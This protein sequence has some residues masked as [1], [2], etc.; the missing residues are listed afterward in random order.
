MRL[1]RAEIKTIATAAAGWGR[2]LVSALHPPEQHEPGDAAAEEQ[3]LVSDAGPCSK[4]AM[5][6]VPTC[7]A[8]SGGLSRPSGT[9]SR[10]DGQFQPVAAPDLGESS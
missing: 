3:Q 4:P 8:F 6:T 2:S 9:N 5:V 7:S 10:S 1:T